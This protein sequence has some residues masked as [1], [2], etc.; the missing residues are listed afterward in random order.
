VVKP[1]ILLK[2]RKGLRKRKKSQAIDATDVPIVRDEVVVEEEVEETKVEEVE[3]EEDVVLSADDTNGRK[4]VE[5]GVVLAPTDEEEQG[6]S[7][8]DKYQK[9]K[10]AAREGMPPHYNVLFG[11]KGD[12]LSEVA[13]VNPREKVLFSTQTMLELLA[14]PRRKERASL[15]FREAYLHFSIAEGGEGRDDIK[16]IGE[17]IAKQERDQRGGAFG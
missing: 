6:E 16:I 14:D 10:I 4:E 2:L 7:V 3:V 13:R 15:V 8:E 1:N 17:Q 12:D 11:R 5:Q 9:D